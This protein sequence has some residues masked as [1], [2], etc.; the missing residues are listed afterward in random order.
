MKIKRTIFAICAILMLCTAA[1]AAEPDKDPS[2]EKMSR[3]GMFRIGVGCG[4]AGWNNINVTPGI[5]FGLGSYRNVV[6]GELGLKYNATIPL[7]AGLQDLTNHHLTL[8]AALLVNYWRWNR[9]C[10]Y[11]GAEIDGNFNVGNLPY[12]S[13]SAAVAGVLGIK[14]QAL[15]IS[16]RYEYDIVPRYNQKYIYET[17]GYDYDAA[18][19]TIFERMRAGVTL[20]Y[21]FTIGL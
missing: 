16:L 13:H 2:A 4:V 3:I 7:K 6:N 15:D 14:V 20:T 19:S 1:H 5:T 17:E 9:N 21:Y 8:S 10:L 18:H 12:S 11:V